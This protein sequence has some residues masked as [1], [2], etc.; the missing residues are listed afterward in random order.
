VSDA[1]TWEL[2][3]MMFVLKLPIAYLIGVVWWAIRAEPRPFEPAVRVGVVDAPR[4]PSSP[5]PWRSRH[6]RRR[7]PVRGRRRATSVRQA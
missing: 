4:L 3:F 5:C 6:T 1:E 2:V 7:A